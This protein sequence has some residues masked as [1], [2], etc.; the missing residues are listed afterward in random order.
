MY[1]QSGEVVLIK[2]GDSSVVG[3]VATPTEEEVIALL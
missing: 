3:V 1:L 2:Q